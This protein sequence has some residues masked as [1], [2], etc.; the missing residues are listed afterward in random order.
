MLI[1][2]KNTPTKSIGEIYLRTIYHHI[3]PKTLFRG[4]TNMFFREKM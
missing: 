1:T 3:T 2:L 4:Q